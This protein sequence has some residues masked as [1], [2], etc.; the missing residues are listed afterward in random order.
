[1]Q[2]KKE[3][4]AI[5]FKLVPHEPLDLKPLISKVRLYGSELRAAVGAEAMVERRERKFSDV[6]IIPD[7]KIGEIV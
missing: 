2:S 6:S 5:L 4:Q 3:E 7:G 1:L